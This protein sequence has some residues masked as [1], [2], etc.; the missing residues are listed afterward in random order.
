MSILGCFTALFEGFAIKT[1]TDRPIGL[2]QVTTFSDD[3]LLNQLS[4]P[5]G[6]LPSFQP[7]LSK[8]AMSKA[9]VA[10]AFV[11]VPPANYNYQNY[12]DYFRQQQYPQFPSRR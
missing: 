10:P 7:T 12:Q 4:S 9:K 2:K 6:P 3:E 1:D 5:I 11:H 8:N